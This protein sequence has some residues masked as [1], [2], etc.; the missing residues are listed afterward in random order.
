MTETPPPTRRVQRVR[1]EIHRRSTTVLQVDRPSPSFVRVLLA[2]PSLAGFVSAGFDD[3]LKLILPGADG[4]PVMRDYTPAAFDTTAG[5]LTL[6]FVLHAHGPASDWARQAQPGQQV[7]VA[8]PR[9]SMVVD[10]GLDWHWLV[11]DA[12]ALPAVARRLAE[13]AELAGDARVTVLLAAPAADRR[14]L[15]G[16]DRLTGLDLRWVDGEKA[17]VDALRALPLP[18]GVGFAWCAAEAI[19]AASLRAALA[20]K[21]LPKEAMR[22]AAYWKRGASSYHA[23]LAD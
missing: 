6:E 13:L 8:G 12:T 5:T 23:E 1:H 7:T 19:T 14:A 17:L 10:A 16:Q 2:D 20:D 3:H 15:P 22:V 11:G 18:A 4:Q 9:G 21:G